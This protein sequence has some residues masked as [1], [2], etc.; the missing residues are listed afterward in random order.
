MMVDESTIKTRGS[1]REGLVVKDRGKKTVIVQ[2]DLVR[3]VP[4]YERY[5]RTRS[6]VA[7]HNPES[8]SAKVGDRVRIE[9]C[10]KISKT[11]AWIVTKVLEKA[12]E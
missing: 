5:I 1:V 10:R 9:E 6:K 8:I 12:G 4:K 7:A 2:R 11:K 3:A